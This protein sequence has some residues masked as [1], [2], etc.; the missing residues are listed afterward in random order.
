MLRDL[1]LLGHG[2]PVWRMPCGCCMRR[3][4]STAL[5][6]WWMCVLR[7]VQPR[8]RRKVRMCSPQTRPSWFRGTSPR[9]SGWLSAAREGRDRHRGSDAGL[10]GGSDG[11]RRSDLGAMARERASGS[12]KPASSS[13]SPKNTHISGEQK[14]FG[15]GAAVARQAPPVL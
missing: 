12:R 3:K 9:E 4:A 15:Q 13:V 11:A 14:D 8:V 5:L 10:G 1:T 7:T 2:L 6:L